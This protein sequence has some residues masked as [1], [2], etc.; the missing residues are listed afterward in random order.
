MPFKKLLSTMLCVLFCFTG[1]SATQ[2]AA[3]PNQTA[4]PLATTASGLAES[5]PT[6]IAPRA[7]LYCAETGQLLLDKNAESSAP[8]ASITKIMTALLVLEHVPDLSVTTTVSYDAVHS[9]EPGSTHIALDTGEVVTIGD[10]LAALLIESA[11]DAAN[12]LAE[13]VGGSLQGFTDMMNEKAAALGCTGTRFANA[14]GLDDPNHYVTAHDMARITAA[15]VQYPDFLTYAG[16]TTYTMPATNKQK[17]ARVWT[18][19]QNM[20]RKSSEWYDPNV[21]AGKNGWTTNAHQTLVTVKRKNGITLIAVSMGDPE[22]KA[23]CLA[24]TAAMFAYGYDQLHSVKLSASRQAEAAAVGFPSADLDALRAQ[25][26]LLPLDKAAS[27]VTLACSG[28]VQSPTL[29]AALNGKTLLTIPLSL[30][31]AGA[32]DT[33]RSEDAV[34]TGV[35]VGR[36]TVKPGLL[37][38]GA[39]G[40]IALGFVSLVFYRTHLIRRQRRRIRAL[41]SR[42]RRY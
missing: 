20:L 38:G 40:F 37:I 22:T 29:T 32:P 28:S 17:E 31:T 35:S 30:M 34:S 27:D 23:H 13:Y 8:P 10:M 11:N 4:P 7:A 12:V 9:I 2:G 25:T 1:A 36:H 18:T 24:D 16:A 6:I 21:I 42:N 26:I 15:A 3:S 41:R 19:K 33:D 5:P 14:H 39:L